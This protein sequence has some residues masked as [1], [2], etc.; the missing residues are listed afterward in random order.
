MEVLELKPT[1][2]SWP[3][4]VIWALR[5]IGYDEGLRRILPLDPRDLFPLFLARKNREATESPFPVSLVIARL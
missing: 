5:D 4:A 1:S 3:H 2:W